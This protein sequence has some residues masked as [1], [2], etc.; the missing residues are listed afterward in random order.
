MTKKPS[1]LSALL[2]HLAKAADRLTDDEIADVAAGRR[3]LILSTE[4]AA[5]NRPAGA[6]DKQ[7]DFG[8]LIA[9]LK[10]AET[11]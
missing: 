2:K 9:S 6:A 3:R 4:E 5:P 7:Q 1:S 11:R 8:S 10:S